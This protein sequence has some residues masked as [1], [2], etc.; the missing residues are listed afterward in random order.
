[1]CSQKRVYV[2]YSTTKELN[3][4]SKAYT[5]WKHQK[6]GK[7]FEIVQQRETESNF[8]LKKIGISFFHVIFCRK[9][10]K[11]FANVQRRS[12]N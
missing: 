2:T 12:L 5:F 8:V 11:N 6:G 9:K 1:M 3:Q 4:C 7:P 10:T